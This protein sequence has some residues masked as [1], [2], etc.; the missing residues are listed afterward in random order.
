[1]LSA[2]VLAAWQRYV[3]AL[4]THFRDRVETYKVWNEPDLCAFWKPHT[5][6]PLDYARLVEATAVVVRRHQPE[7]RVAVGAAAHGTEAV[8]LQFLDACFRAGM[9]RH[10][11]VVTFHC[12]RNRPEGQS[13]AEIEAM[14]ALLRRHGLGHVPLWEGECGCP[15]VGSDTEA[16]AGQPW[17]EAK[18]ATWL[19]RRLVIDLAR[20][21]DLVTYFHA[22]DFSGYVKDGTTG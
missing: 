15:S 10:A 2:G 22:S 5:P 20:V 11:D 21:L 13:S 3:T 16:L 4:V 7:A 9:T 1:M 8:G 18:Q 14:R 17:D 12:Y 6:D 19:L